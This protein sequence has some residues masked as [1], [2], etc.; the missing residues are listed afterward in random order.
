MRNI[1][2]VLPF[3][4][5]DKPSAIR[6]LKWISELGGCPDN[7]CLLIGSNEIDKVDFDVSMFRS[8]L[9]IQ[10]SF[11]LKDETHPIGPNRMFETALLHMTRTGATKPFLWLEPDCVPMRAGW[12]KS[13]EEEYATAIKAQKT[14]LASVVELKDERF[15]PRIPSGVAV[16]PPD[17]WKIY[18]KIQT[19]RKIAW[20]IQFADAAIKLT[21]PSTRITSRMNR[22]YPPT[23]VSKR[24]TQ[25]HAMTVDQIPP[26]AVLF[27]PSKDAQNGAAR[28]DADQKS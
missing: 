21:K 16:Y 12:I 22:N 2:I 23:F 20:D 28:F 18:S 19:N 7:D 10:P 6:L 4:K 3:C 1:L 26:S 5:K 17:A 25:T 13:I 8:H 14:I 27:H 11:P 9:F 24:T 15:P